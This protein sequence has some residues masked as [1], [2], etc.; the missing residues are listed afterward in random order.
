MKWAYGLT[1][2]PQRRQ[3]LLVQTLSSL[4]KAGFPEPRLFI[5][6][7]DNATAHHLYGYFNLP[8]VCRYPTIRA[9]GNWILGL[10]ELYI[11]EPTADRYAMFQDDFVTY[12]NLRQYLEVTP[13][14]DHGYLNLYTF[15]S[16]QS[17][18]PKDSSGRNK[19]GWYLSNQFGRGA[20]A[21][22]FDR[23]TVLT[24]L[25]HQHMVDR[26]MNAHR[27]HKSIDGG[28][29]TALTKAGWYEYVHNP[30]LVQHV[31]LLSTMGHLP[32]KKS[33]SFLGEEFDA[34][35]LVQR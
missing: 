33:T 30:S 28:V 2:V 31:G 29:V 22:V 5:D 9:Y 32:H 7:V 27:G 16:N 13:Y 10:A 23:P 19:V 35:R 12:H 24:L 3:D 17:I 34:L 18:C 4:S 8:M 26:P 15:I 6:G 25:T 1:T 11:R 20:V 14:P 21:L